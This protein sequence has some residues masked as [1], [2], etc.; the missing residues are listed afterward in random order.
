MIEPL[1]LSEFVT[2]RQL[3]NIKS[4]LVEPMVD[5]AYVMLTV[6][7]IAIKVNEIIVELNKD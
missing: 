5:A 6:E 7:A 3:H 4:D 1:D 2:L